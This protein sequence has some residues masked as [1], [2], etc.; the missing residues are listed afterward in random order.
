MSDDQQKSQV[1]LGC[2]AHWRLYELREP[3][4]RSVAANYVLGGTKDRSG[5]ILDILN[6]AIK[7]P[8]H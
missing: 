2:S 3:L 1:L 4:A 8:E 5:G 6:W 7:P